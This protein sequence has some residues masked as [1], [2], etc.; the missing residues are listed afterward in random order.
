MESCAPLNVETVETD[1]TDH[2]NTSWSSKDCDSIASRDLVE[3]MFDTLLSN[4]EI[5]IIPSPILSNNDVQLLPDFQYESPSSEELEQFITS[6]LSSQLELARSVCSSTP[7]AVILKQRLLIL[8]RIYFAIVSKYHERELF[9]A[10]SSNNYN[11]LMYIPKEPVMA[12]RALLEIGVQTGLSLLFSL[13]RQNWMNSSHLGVPSLCNS[14]LKTALDMIQNLPSLSLANDLHLTSLGVSSLE[15]VSCFLKEA[16]LNT[17]GVDKQGQMLATEL[18]LGLALQRGS[19]RFL[20]EWIEMALD[21]S[22]DEGNNCRIT[23]YAFQKALLLMDCNKQKAKLK[24]NF[25]NDEICLY[26][27]ALYLMEE[28][29]N[30]AVDCERSSSSDNAVTG[31]CKDDSG[32]DC[33]IWGSNSSHQLAEG[34]QEKIIVPVKS[35]VFV[36]IQT[37]EAGQYCTFLIY[38]D[39]S[40]SSCGKGTYGRL[41]LGDSATQSTPKRVLIDSSVKKISSSKG[42]DGHSLA[43]TEDGLVYSWGDGDY[44]KLGHNNSNTEKQPKLVGGPLL[45]KVVI[46][47]QAG[48]RHSAAVTEDGELYTWGEGDHGRLGHGDSNP[49][50]IPT[51]VRDLSDVGGVACGCAHTLALSKDGTTVW[52]FGS[53][54]SGRL[55]HGEIAKVYRPKVIEALQGMIIRKVCAGTTFSVAL[56]NSGQVYTWGSGPCLGTGSVDTISVLPTL[57]QDLASYTIVDVSAGDI[58]CLAL[59]DEG[60]VFAWGNNAMGQCGVGH[61]NSP[62]S[63]PQKVL[64]LVG[65]NV[66]QISAGTSH[67][68]A[69]TATPTDAQP[70]T[71]H[72]PFCLDLNEKTFEY[73]RKF[74]EKYSNGFYEDKPPTPFKTSNEHNEF[75]GQ[76]LKL[77][78]THL[79]MCVTGGMSSHILGQQAKGLRMILFRL[80]DISTPPEIQTHIQ[81]VLSN[82]ASFLL[83]QLK[84]RIEFLNEQLPHI[85]TLSQGQQMLLEIVLYSLEEPSY[86]AT[87]L[88]YSSLPE[89]FDSKDLYLTETLMASLLQT[90]SVTTEQT[91]DSVVHHIESGAKSNWKNA[92]SS[93][94]SHL[95]KLLSSLQNH[96][97]AHCIE[98]S[99]CICPQPETT[100]KS[101]D[102]SSFRLLINHFSYLFPLA[103]RLF[104]KTANILEKH[105]SSLELFYNVLLDSLCGSMLLKIL[106]SML[107]MP[108]SFLSP[109]LS[110][111]LDLLP[112]LQKLNAHLPEEVQMDSDLIISG[113]ETPTLTQLAEQSWIWLIDLE[114]TCSFLVG[115]RLGGM[116]VGDPPTDDEKRCQKWLKTIIFSNG[117][118][119][120]HADL[121]VINEIVYLVLLNVPEQISTAIA[122]LSLETQV[123]CN[124]AL[125]L[126]CQYDEACAVQS[127]DVHEKGFYDAMIETSSVETWDRDD[128]DAQLLETTVRCF[129]ITLLKHASLL[130]KSMSN[131]SVKVMY[132]IAMG[133]RRKLLMPKMQYSNGFV[134]SG[135][136]GEISSDRENDLEFQGEETSK[137]DTTYEF[138]VKCH[139]VLERCLFILCFIKDIEL[140]NELQFSSSDENFEVEK[141]Y[142][143]FYENIRDNFKSRNLRNFGMTLMQYVSDTP[144]IKTDNNTA[145]GWLTEPKIIY[146]ALCFQNKRAESR[147][148]CLDEIY[149]LLFKSQAEGCPT[150]INH[151]QQYLLSGCFGLNNIDSND[152]CTQLH[153]YLEGI[154]ASPQDIQEKIRERVHRIYRLLIH[155]LAKD[156]DNE[157]NRNLKLLVIFVLS[158][159]YFPDDLILVVENGLMPLLKNICN[160]QLM[161]SSIINKRQTL[162]VA[163]K[164]LLY[165]L[166][167]SC[168]LHSKKLEASVIENVVDQLYE[169]FDALIGNNNFL[170]VAEVLKHFPYNRIMSSY[171]RTLGDFIVFLRTMA[172]SKSIQRLIG[173][174]RWIN[175]L[176]S[177]LESKENQLPIHVHALRP[178]LLAIQLLQTVLPALKSSS[179]ECKFRQEVVQKIYDSLADQ[180]WME[181]GNFLETEEEKHKAIER[182][183]DRLENYRGFDDFC[184]D[185]D[186]NLPIHNMGFDLDKCCNCTVEGGL[187]LVHGPDGKGYGLGS[188]VIKSGCYQ[189][190]ILIV[191]E[192][193]GNEGTCIGVSKYPIKDFSHR[194]TSDMWLYRAYSG[195]LYHN[196]ERDLSLQS[197]TQGDYITVVLDM[198]AKTLSFGKNGEEPKIAFEEIEETELYPCVMFY[199]THP[200]EKVK[201][202]DMLI[203]TKRDLLPGDPDLSPLAIVLAESH[204]GLLRKLHTSDAWTEEI[205]SCILNGLK[206]ITHIF[207]ET[208]ILDET[209]KSDSTTNFDTKADKLCKLVWPALAIIGGADRGLRMG[210]LCIHKTSRR[211][212][213]VMGIL[214]KGVTVIKVLWLP[215]GDMSDVSY[216]SLEHVEPV[217]FNAI[218]LTGVTGDILKNLIRLSGVTDRIK[219]PEYKLTNAEKDLLKN[220]NIAQSRRNSSV[221]DGW[222]S[223]SDSQVSKNSG[224]KQNVIRTVESLTNELVFNILGEVKK[225]STKKMTA[226]GSQHGSS[227]CSGGGGGGGNGGSMSVG[228]HERAQTQYNSYDLKVLQAKLLAIERYCLQLAYLQFSALKTLNV[229]LISNKYSDILLL[230]SNKWCQNKEQPDNLTNDLQEAIREIMPH[231][232]KKSISECKLKHMIDIVEFERAQSVL[233]SN[234]LKNRYECD[235]DI[236]DGPQKI[237]SSMDGASSSSS[238]SSG[239]FNSNQRMCSRSSATLTVPRVPTGFGFS[240]YF[241]GPMSDFITQDRDEFWSAWRRS[242]SPSHPPPIAAPLLEMGFTLRHILRAI[243]ATKSSGEVSAHTMQVL[244]TWMLEHPYIGGESALDNGTVAGAMGPA[245]ALDSANSAASIRSEESTP[246]LRTTRFLHPQTCP[247]NLENTEVE[248]IFGRCS[249][250]TGNEF[251]N[252]LVERLEQME[253]M[254]ERER[255]RPHMRGETHPL[256]SSNLSFDDGVDTS[257]IS[258]MSN[259]HN[260]QVINVSNSCARCSLCGHL[261]ANLNSHM[262]SYHPG[263]GSIWGP[264]CCG[265]LLGTHYILCHKCT[266]REVSKHKL[267]KPSRRTPAPDIIFDE[268]DKTESLEED[269]ESFKFSLPDVKFVLGLKDNFQPQA[270]PMKEGDYLGSSVVPTVTREN[271]KCEYEA[272]YLGRQANNLTT[273]LDRITAHSHFTQSIQILLSR[274]IVLNVLSILARSNSSANLVHGLEIIGLDDVPTVVKLMT[275]IAMNRIEMNNSTPAVDHY[276]NVA[277]LSKSLA[278][279]SIRSAAAHASLCNL[280]VSIA[281]LAQNNADASKMVVSMCTKDLIVSSMGILMFNGRFAVTQALVNILSSH[282]GSSLLDMA[283]EEAPLGSANANHSEPLALANALAAYILSKQVAHQNKEW[284]TEQLFK[285]IATKVQMFS[286]PNSDQVNFADLSDTLPHIQADSLEGHD[287]GVRMLA[288]CE[289]KKL[290]ASS[291]LDGTVRVWNFNKKECFYLEHMFVFHESINVYGA[292]LQG[293]TIGHLKWSPNG[294]FVAAAMENVINVWP[295][296]NM[297]Q[298]REGLQKWFI[299]GQ[300]EF[301]TT[302]T[303]PQIKREEDL[304]G[305]EYLLIG[306]ID[307]SV[308]LISITSETKEV[309]HLSNCSLQHAVVATDWYYEHQYFAVGFIDGTLKFGVIDPTG[310]VIATKAHES[311]IT[312]VKW[313]PGGTILATASADL[314]CKIWH[315]VQDEF[316]LLHSF[317]QPHE[318]VS[319]QWSPLIGGSSFPFLIIIGTSYGSVC[320]WKLPNVENIDKL[321]PQMVMNS[322]GH[323]Y[324][325]VTTISI[326]PKGLFFAS[327]CL[328]GSST[329]VNIWSLHDGSLLKTITGSGGVKYDGLTWINDY[330]LGIAFSRSKA[331]IILKYGPEQYKEGMALATARTTLL[332]KGIRG[333]QSAPF[334]KLLVSYLPVILQCQYNFE[335]FFVQTGVNLMHSL[336]FKSLT[337]LAL[338][339]E[340]DKCLCHPVKPFNDKI[341]GEVVQEYSWLHVISL[342]TKMANSLVKRIELPANI[343]DHIDASP[344]TTTEGEVDSKVDLAQTT[345][346]SIK[347]DEQIMQWITQRPQDW[348]IGGKCNAYLW[349]SDRHGQLAEVGCSALTPTVVES[350]STAKKIICGQNCTFVIQADG[351][352]LA[353][354]EGSYGRLGQGNSDDLHSLSVISSLQG[355]VITDLATSV[356]SDGHSLALAESGEVFSWGDG[357]FGKLG[358]GN[359][360]RQRRPRQIDA[361]QDEEVVQVACGFKHSAVV[362]ADGKLFTFGNGDYGRLGLGSTSNK[363]NP[364][365]VTA[366]EGYKIGQV[367]CGLNHTACVSS[368]GMIVWTFGEGEFGK[369]GLGHTSTIA[370]PQRVQSMCNIGIKKVG[371]GTNLTVFLTKDGRIFVCGID[372]IP[373]QVHPRERTDYKPQQLLSLAE[374]KVEDFSIGTEHVLFLTS[375]G[376]V[377]GWGINSEGQLGLPHMSL[378][379]EPELICELSDKGIK[380][381]STG[382]THSAAWTA[383]PHP[384]DLPGTS[385]SLSFGLPTEIPVQYTHLQ[386]LSIKA[387]QIRLKFLYNFSDKLYSCWT[388]IPMGAE[389]KNMKVPPLEGLTSSKL[390]PLLAP[391]V[392]TLPLVRCIGKTMVQGRNYGPQ[393]IVKRISNKGKKCKPIF[394][395]VA[396]QV[397]SMKP[398]ELRLP[399][400]AWKVKL[401]GEGADD[402]GG[403]FDDTITEMCQEIISGVVPILVPTPNAVND[404]G[405]NRDKYLFNPQLTNQQ[406]LQWFKFLG[407]LFGVAM[408]TRKPLAVPLAPMM[409][410]LIVDEPITVEDL[411]DVDSMYVQSLRSIRD[412]HLSGITEANFHD[413]IP[414]EWFEGTSCTGKIVPIVPGGRNIPLTFNNRTQ[415]FEQAVSFRFHEFDLQVAAVR[416]GM[417]GIIPVPLL[418]LV[419]SEHMEQLV[420]G[421]PH[422]SIASLKKIV[423]YRDLD[424]NHQLVQWLWNILGNFTNAERVLFMRFVSGRSRL[425]ANLADLSQRFQIMKVDRALNSL[426]TAQTCFFQLRLPPYSTQEV[427]AEKLKYSIY[428]CRTIDMDNYMLARNTEHG[429]ASDEEF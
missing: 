330:S 41:G 424:E 334:L 379:R 213:I 421:L 86:I 30:M 162:N 405:F 67:S 425:P 394:I 354:G 20:L 42:S 87:L 94:I 76:C 53:G 187:T 310:D 177:L 150:A 134:S 376:K 178:K 393:V 172:A 399:S 74:L 292:E 47:V 290:L 13:L 329:V 75:L 140:E 309:Q 180:M 146:S 159:R 306:R 155:S 111:I 325:P 300:K 229:L 261:S 99:R 77:L 70:V 107:L 93:R 231:L 368:D 349:G 5:R 218:K 315:K 373:W 338:L 258:S 63:R 90:F 125:N 188:Q 7:F 15:Q 390:R 166:A 154:Q 115:Q 352:V 54:D 81:E 360:D 169:Q 171:S 185:V 268:N 48:Y 336:F 350:F 343:I 68:I 145:V 303:W 82:G 333:L 408:R 2:T 27:V 184:T 1:W 35:K 37:A 216:P 335:K 142:V 208:A 299:D 80:V 254:H 317:I 52:S 356:G 176:V 61:I 260:C 211:K 224:A 198:D 429:P 199:S 307:G 275:L 262:M 83:P 168:C 426:P 374:Y 250:R 372:R 118:A 417:A 112:S 98:K 357:D 148:K 16:V 95:R 19:L 44:G 14:V 389:Q 201:M 175:K 181:H 38:R 302:M 365:Q 407:I 413:I 301:I 402:A 288:W 313:G 316:R 4:K 361:L 227:G 366:L 157:R 279:T 418:S 242:N 39:G 427:M 26:E 137:E 28:L 141:P 400:R 24:F 414:L 346:W 282:G 78:C 58:H 371:C 296:R 340:L 287:H 152:S 3:Y 369:L 89:K 110:K 278:D 113:T 158:R 259:N 119:I 215:D 55:G 347:Q 183:L 205:N 404:E 388:L 132:G 228:L 276:A 362:T 6:L 319:L 416:E 305:K 293:K 270:I 251:R 222:R 419:T 105:S 173:T 153:H 308:S 62:I 217:Q 398:H 209:P 96:L 230:A 415:Y 194:T 353:C 123:Y 272:R 196:G 245:H 207:P 314:T 348:Q 277:T 122:K 375:C 8:K 186:E 247:H 220:E 235:G 411:E 271:Q 193:K 324:N 359:S 34:I 327:G 339:L 212:G 79:N 59:S 377:F 32:S 298:E 18:L 252:Y 190:K 104:N 420:C 9:K 385:R 109:I 108:G 225:I 321:E 66:R 130:K 120:D 195:S 73:L 239:N 264:G 285:C 409:W 50:N 219:F 114:R 386:G 226:A 240:N 151:V 64:G 131:P 128:G 253:R 406:H 396:K 412:I 265:N 312:S 281:A 255:D 116:L 46:Q 163:C 326:H 256:M 291:G 322:Q 43:L 237:N 286:H 248:S 25:D 202:T 45:G 191:K 143:D 100:E 135:S 97:L 23:S 267:S 167:I 428:N 304:N 206:Q 29:V 57:V 351:T 257:G 328:K 284:A 56:T 10:S 342:T 358:H 192:S 85:N 189:W 156:I 147:L 318:P 273:S 182:A 233:H 320:V 121:E 337:S 214:K 367:A 21:A 36:Q 295:T 92:N 283:K 65:V 129:L 71:R 392:Y 144:N 370:I 380:Q 403:V 165:I 170:N 331:I 263:C 72:K 381:I 101:D 179:V 243:N 238:M 126:P 164:R 203:H 139:R 323:S 136:E 378:A 31:N 33:F 69:W 332:Q 22:T 341:D 280:S 383:A 397:V 355:F 232:V 221:S 384:Q 197:Y 91:L 60:E 40:V 12:S 51:L 395:Q 174:P 124:L 103:S 138:R 410:K 422:I 11:D 249:R 344:T 160:F 223:T 204:I 345:F 244:T 423:R 269:V 274:S 49:R 364:E 297:S 149:E 210:G 294:D 84:E 266:D 382:R 401:I 241:S 289:K 363:K 117:L 234:F 246:S 17:P 127:E 311:A 387:I 102:S 200:G 88:G 236:E 391:K 161:S 106:N 133:L